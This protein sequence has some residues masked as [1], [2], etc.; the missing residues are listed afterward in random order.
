MKPTLCPAI[1][2]GI[3]FLFLL[4]L[5]P[6]RAE[7]D[8]GSIRQA[9]REIWFSGGGKFFNYKE[10]L[11]PPYIPD[12]ERGWL[13][14]FAAGGSYRGEYNFYAAIDGSYTSGE[15]VYR[16][17][18]LESP[19]TPFQATTKETVWDASLRLGKGF[20]L[21]EAMVTPFVELGYR[22][23]DRDFGGGD[24][25]TYQNW[26]VLG[27]VLFESTPLPKVTFSAYGAAGTTFVPE[28]KYGPVR[29]ELGSA[30]MYKVG[31]KVGYAVFNNAE[32]F[33]AFDY[34]YFRYLQSEPA[35]DYTYEPTS[36]T[37]ETLFR[38]GVAYR[39]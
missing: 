17:A 14:S 4:A 2:A 7:A 29:Y 20:D 21:S 16:G 3:S 35:F 34:K 33:T 25:E 6:S 39:Y 1:R 23:W 9:D 12:S 36:K 18:L 24:V 28:L 26:D 8:L 13:P 19:S 22:Y 15:T 11:F 31:G 5:F 38:L 37:A 32:V 30:G 10:P 27:G